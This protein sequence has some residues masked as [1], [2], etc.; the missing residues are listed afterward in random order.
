MPEMEKRV[1]DIKMAKFESPSLEN[2]IL[3]QSNFWKR[4]YVWKTFLDSNALLSSNTFH[5]NPLDFLKFQTVM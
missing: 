2:V 5:K 4:K 1:E 3:W